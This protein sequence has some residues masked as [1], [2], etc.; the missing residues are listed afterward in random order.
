MPTLFFCN[1][2]NL[3]NLWTILPVVIALQSAGDIQLR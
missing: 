2:C 1:L 3:R